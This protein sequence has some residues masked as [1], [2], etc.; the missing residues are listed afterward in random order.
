MYVVEMLYSSYLGNSILG[1]VLTGP[2]FK[3]LSLKGSWFVEGRRWSDSLV[4]DFVE[5]FFDFAELCFLAL[6]TG[7]TGSSLTSSVIERNSGALA[8]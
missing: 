2:A 6:T 7:F 4:I 3:V 5:A 8:R 1:L